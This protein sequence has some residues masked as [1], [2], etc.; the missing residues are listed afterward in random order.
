[1]QC[2]VLN[3]LKVKF[4]LLFTI[5]PS[6]VE[7]TEDPFSSLIKPNFDRLFFT[8]CEKKQDF[9][10]LLPDKWVFSIFYPR[11][12]WKT[13]AKYKKLLKVKFQLLFTIKPSGVKYTEYPFSSLIK[14]CF[15]CCFF[16][17]VWKNQALNFFSARQMGIQ[18]ILPHTFLGKSQAFVNW[19]WKCIFR[20]YLQ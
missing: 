18:Y 17:D 3:V 16:Y 2:I 6:G 11:R 14:L 15:E 12:F 8:T 19:F 4:Q 1:M 7:R 13:Q 20:L 9:N 10:F 5:K